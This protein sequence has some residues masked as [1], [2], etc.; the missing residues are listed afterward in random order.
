M[1]TLRNVPE[2]SADENGDRPSSMRVQSFLHRIDDGQ[3]TARRTR[4]IG[5]GV[6]TS[7]GGVAFLTAIGVVPVEAENIVLSASA[8]VAGLTLSR[9]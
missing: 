7:I 9:G 3:K 5:L 4:F 2:E 6:A 1:S 8:V